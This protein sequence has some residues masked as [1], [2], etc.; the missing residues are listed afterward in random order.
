MESYF[1]CGP[2]NASNYYVLR[3]MQQQ[4]ELCD[5]VLEID[6]GKKIRAHKYILSA[7]SPYFRAMFNT[8]FSECQQGMVKLRDRDREILQAVISYI[9]CSDVC[10]PSDQVLSLLMVADKFQMD[11][12]V[13]ECRLI[14]Q[15]RSKNNVSFNY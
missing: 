15:K 11:C 9:Y 12:L 6:S 5:S 1:Y 14:M 13:E 7:T 8:P 3:A 4:V 2:T 10:L